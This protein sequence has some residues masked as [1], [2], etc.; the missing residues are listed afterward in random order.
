MIDNF[1]RVNQEKLSEISVDSKYFVKDFNEFLDIGIP[2]LLKNLLLCHGF[3]K[4]V[5]SIFLLKCLK[6]ML[7][8]YFSK[9]FG[10]L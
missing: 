6:R 3:P 9:L 4:K 2:Y 8:L 7:E 5:K 1:V 10:I